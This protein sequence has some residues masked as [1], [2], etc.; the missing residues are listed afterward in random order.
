MAGE[1]EHEVVMSASSNAEIVRQFFDAIYAEDYDR[2]FADY[3]DPAYRFVV[4]SAANPELQAAIPWAGRTLQGKT[5]YLELVGLLFGEFE[6]ISFETDGYAE[7]DD[8]VFV[9][10]HFRFRHR[11]TGKFADSDWLAR[12]EMKDGRIAGGRFYENT[13]A[14]A[15]ARTDS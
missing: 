14:V 4:G 6:P 8:Q 12:F 2:A 3:A 7:A 5:G 9:E 11:R 13:Y 1:H 15:A 10:G